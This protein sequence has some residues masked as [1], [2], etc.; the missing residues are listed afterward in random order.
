MLELI[1]LPTRTR[2]VCRVATMACAAGL[3]AC[4]ASSSNGSPGLGH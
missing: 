3:L 1:Q 4:G 2:T